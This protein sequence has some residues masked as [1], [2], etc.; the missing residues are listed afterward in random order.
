MIRMHITVAFRPVPEI[1]YFQNFEN[2]LF[3]LM[4]LRAIEP[5]CYGR[6]RF[7]VFFSGHVKELQK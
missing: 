7:F 3:M 2:V 5:F 4:L 6:R 1:G